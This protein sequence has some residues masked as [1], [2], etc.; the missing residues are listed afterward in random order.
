MNKL[1]KFKE[2]SQDP[3][4]Q[5]LMRGTI[6]LTS[7][8]DELVTKLMKELYDDWI[9]LVLIK[10]YQ[11]YNRAERIPDN[12]RWNDINYS[13]PI[14]NM[15][16]RPHVLLENPRAKIYN[17]IHDYPVSAD[18]VMF[19]KIF[20][21][22]KFLPKTV[23]QEREI[24][25]LEFPIIAKPKAGFSAQGIELFKTKEEALESMTEFD[26]W[27]EAKNIKTEFRLFIMNGEIIHLAE[28]IKN[29]KND[30]SV[31]SK[32]KDE[33]I[34]LVYIDQDWKTFPENLKS[35]LL[36]LHEEVKQKVNL[37]FYDIDLILDTEEEFWVPE[38]NGAPGI[39]PSMFS[40]IYTAWIEMTLNRPPKESTIQRLNQ[41]RDIHREFMKNT[42]KKEYQV[43]INPVK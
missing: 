36:I 19:S 41:I 30:K 3:K 1:L 37:D 20:S 42:Y 25:Q 12:R 40:A 24:N 13:L 11:D 28:R 39:G 18:K 9:H 17:K 32:D 4:I 23:F 27:S 43:S 35:K 8:A 38:I 14:L 16:S 34:D 7:K 2:F 33:K 26:L 6:G 21:G 22:S 5:I 31:G 29:S 15:T 10:K